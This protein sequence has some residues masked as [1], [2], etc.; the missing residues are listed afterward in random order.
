MRSLPV[1]MPKALQDMLRVAN[2]AELFCIEQKDGWGEVN[3]LPQITLLKGFEILRYHIEHLLT[4]L[5][6]IEDTSEMKDL[7]WQLNY[8]AFADA[9]DG[10]FLAINLEDK[11]VFFLDHEYAYYPIGYESQD[12]GWQYIRLADSLESWMRLVNS[13]QGKKGLNAG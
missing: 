1:E 6:Y 12:P 13:T 8:L 7:P 4:Y 3:H 2:G 9:L 10:N 5:T 11:S